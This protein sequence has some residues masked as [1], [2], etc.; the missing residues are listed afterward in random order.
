[1]LLTAT[2]RL[3]QALQAVHGELIRYATMGGF[4]SLVHFVTV[5]SLVQFMHLHPV[6]ANTIGYAVGFLVSFAGHN[7]WTFAGHN[8]TIT[9]SLPRFIIIAGINFVLNQT[10]FY[11]LHTKMAYPIALIIT[12]LAAGL[13]SFLLTKIWAFRREE[14]LTQ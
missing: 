1:M 2:N 5:V 12:L 8:C 6:E 14:T 11:V 4:A 7:N 9:Y 13:V 10:L 3:R